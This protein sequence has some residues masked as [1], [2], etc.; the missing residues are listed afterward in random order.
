[1]TAR[2][3]STQHRQTSMLL[4]GHTRIERWSLMLLLLLKTRRSLNQNIIIRSIIPD[5]RGTRSSIR[6]TTHPH[7][8]RKLLLLLTSTRL[9]FQERKLFQLPCFVLTISCRSC[10]G[11]RSRCRTGKRSVSTRWM[12]KGRVF[13]KMA[14][15][16]WIARAGCGWSS[17]RGLTSVEVETVESLCC[18]L[19]AVCV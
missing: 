8:L 9:C 1:M 10:W 4:V 13:L 14:E 18:C 3:L 11:H 16:G 19:V 5:H 2:E 6:I 15:V 17:A 12:R 7:P